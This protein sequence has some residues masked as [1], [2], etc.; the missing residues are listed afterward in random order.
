MLSTVFV[1]M[2]WI[3][4]EGNA[5]EGVIR[6]TVFISAWS[7]A[8]EQK[9]CSAIVFQICLPSCFGSLAKKTVPEGVINQSFHQCLL[10]CVGSLATEC[11]RRHNQPQCFI[12]ARAHALDLWQTW[13]CRE[14]DQPECLPRCLL[15]CIGSLAKEGGRGCHQPECPSSM[16]AL[17]RWIHGKRQGV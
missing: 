6:R 4:G 13:S 16:L 14:C 7:H 3:P 1:P 9:A 11:C 15:S 5:A 12:D 10:S 2:R 8:L 17:M